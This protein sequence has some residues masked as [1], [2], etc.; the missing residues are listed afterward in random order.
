[1]MGRTKV[2]VAIAVWL[3][4]VGVA[5]G[6]LGRSPD[7]RLY[8]LE[9]APGERVSGPGASAGLVVG[10]IRL[11]RYLERPEIARREGPS[12]VE[13]D[14]LHRWAGDLEAN[15]LRALSSGLAQRLSNERVASYPGNPPFPVDARVRV[16]FGELVA[17]ED[18]AVHLQAVW[19]IEPLDRATDTVVES[20]D[21]RSDGRGGG[22]AAIVEGHDEAVGR[23]AD[24]IAAR[25]A[26]RDWT[27][28]PEASTP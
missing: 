16:D 28:A 6:C 19:S 14:S 5:G 3:G 22:I 12:R 27:P 21:I 18:G 2:A 26:E 13:F 24:A 20:I 25:L 11:P 10:P 8:T 4:L 15:V 17:D 23:L 7:V 1:M 9:G